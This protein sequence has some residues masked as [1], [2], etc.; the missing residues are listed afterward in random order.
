MQDVIGFCFGLIAV[1][2]GVMGLFVIFSSILGEKD[3]RIQ[4]AFR[5]GFAAGVY[6][7][8]GDAYYVKGNDTKDLS[9]R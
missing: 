7:K 2:V 5:D 8:E 1:G 4:Q 3:D 9:K 6:K